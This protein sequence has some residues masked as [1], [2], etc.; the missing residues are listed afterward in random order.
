[1]PAAVVVAILTLLLGIQPV[2]TDLYLPALPTLQ[3][4]LGASVGGAQLTLSTLIICFGFSQ[5]LFVYIVIK[6]ARG[7]AKATAKVWDKPEGLEWTVPSPAPYH[8]F[9]DAPEVK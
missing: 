8:T 3:R 7:G 9:E 1:M 5:L 6:C 2:T 4:D